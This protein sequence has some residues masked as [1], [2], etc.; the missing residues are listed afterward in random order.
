MISDDFPMKP[1]AERWR[2]KAKAETTGQGLDCLAEGV[3]KR[4]YLPPKPYP[5]R[6][7]GPGQA[8]LSHEP[9]NKN[10]KCF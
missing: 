2:A 4:S 8:P 5:R 7:Q 10:W 3:E 6:P 1:E 9:W